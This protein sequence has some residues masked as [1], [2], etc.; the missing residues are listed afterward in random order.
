[1]PKTDCPLFNKG[2]YIEKINQ[3]EAHIGMCCFQRLSDATYTAIDFQ[4][5]DYLTYIRTQETNPKECVSCF[6]NEEIGN[7]SYRQGQQRAFELQG[8][9]TDSINELI[10]FSYNCENTC[11]LKCITC[12]PNFSSMWK[13]DYEKLGYPID[14]KVQKISGHRNRI[15]DSLDL[16]SVR[17][18]HFQG[19]EPLLT[20]D[21]ENIMQKVGDLSKAIVSYNTNATIFPSDTTLKLWKQTQLTKLYFSIDATAEQ[22]EYIRFP[23]NWKQAVGNMTRIRDLGISNVWIELGVTVGINN[24]FYLQDI[25]DWKNS[26]FSNMLTG[27]AINI[28]VNFVEPMNF[29]GKALE[30]KNMNQRL[31]TSAIEYVNGLTDSVIK[32]AVLGYLQNMQPINHTDW[33][34]YLDSLDNIRNTDWRKTLSRLYEIT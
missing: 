13:P 10:S 8:C 20:D 7:Q 11:N 22:F 25:I 29:G 28:Y 24:L 27:D 18:L 9:N 33:T 17:L 34:D 32:Q 19:G 6:H 2:L 14:T 31:L 21:H 23:A 1:M 5:N 15:Y 3:T 30:L 12:G 16:T 4:T 26:Q